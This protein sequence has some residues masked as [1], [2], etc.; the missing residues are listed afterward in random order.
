MLAG[1]IAVGVAGSMPAQ[2]VY[3]V[4]GAGDDGSKVAGSLTVTPAATTSNSPSNVPVTQPAPIHV[5]AA[6]ICTNP[7]GSIYPLEGVFVNCHASAFTDL[8]LDTASIVWNFGDAGSQ[9]NTL[10]GFNAAHSYASAGN[11]TITLTI[12]LATGQVSVASCPV[13]IAA[14]NRPVTHLAS[15]ASL[16]TLQSG[17]CNLLAPGGT[18]T[19]PLALSGKSHIYVGPDAGGG[20]A[21]IITSSNNVQDVATDGNTTA[22]VVKGLSLTMSDQSADAC[23]ITGNSVTFLGCT[24]SNL[25]DCF[26][27]N[28]EPVNVLI[29]GNTVPSA[30]LNTISNYFVWLEGKEINVYGNTVPNTVNQS[31]IRADAPGTSDINIS[32]NNLAKTTPSGNTYKSCLTLQWYDYLYAGNNTLTNGPM[33]TGPLTNVPGSNS[34]SAASSQN[35]ILDSNTLN[36][37]K[38]GINAESIN[39]MVCNNVINPPNTYGI[40]VSSTDTSF[41]GVTWQVQNLW[42]ENNTVDSTSIYG[43]FLFLTDGEAQNVIM[44]NNLLVNPDLVIGPAQTFYVYVANNDLDSFSEI[45]NNAWGTPASVM[46]WANG[47]VFFMNAN[48]SNNV[49]CLTPAE[50]EKTPLNGG[51]TPMGDVYQF[52]TLTTTYSTTQNGI[53]YGSTLTKGN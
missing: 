11:Y 14:D 9:Y 3:Q 39:T 35:T 23:D 45:K 32:Y 30:N 20:A 29:E 6:I 33:F 27:L 49:G 5:G 31:I 4:S 52:P 25:S 51:A 21:P 43:G 46:S 42:I 36:N 19:G 1:C 50:W 41:P 10:K 7:P 12:T 40:F 34:S 2:V 47:G 22:C 18:F 38:I 37:S 44:D 17:T 16:A 8:Q 28:Q 13:T 53:V 15:G 26:N 48:Q 24:L